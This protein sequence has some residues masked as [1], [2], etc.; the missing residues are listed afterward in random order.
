MEYLMEMRAYLFRVVN[1]DCFPYLSIVK[2]FTGFILDCSSVSF[3]SSDSTFISSLFPHQV[4]LCG[5]KI[6]I[7]LH[8]LS[9]HFPTSE[10]KIR[11][12]ADVASVI[13]VHNSDKSKPRRAF[14][15]AFFFSFSIHFGTF[16]AILIY[17]SKVPCKK[18]TK[19]IILVGRLFR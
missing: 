6:I 7:V 4:K 9:Y 10:K 15:E 18:A 16:C 12:S 2:K 17:N 11:K 19:I 1:S 3:I 8:I 13:Q 5:I 14:K